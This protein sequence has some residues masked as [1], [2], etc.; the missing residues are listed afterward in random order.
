[1]RP[2]VI[3]NFGVITTTKGLNTSMRHSNNDNSDNVVHGVPEPF[4]A[5]LS[6]PDCTI[7][8][9]TRLRQSCRRTRIWAEQSIESGTKD[10]AVSGFGS[11]FVLQ[12]SISRM[13]EA[14]PHVECMEWSRD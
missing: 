7:G 11:I 3:K 4:L 14:S 2:C 1:M 13:A 8:L 12:T 9:G 6:S 10:P 5:V